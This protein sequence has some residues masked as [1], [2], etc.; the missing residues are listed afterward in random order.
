[1]N[2]FQAENAALHVPG[3]RHEILPTPGVLARV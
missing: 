1:V 2:S 3:F